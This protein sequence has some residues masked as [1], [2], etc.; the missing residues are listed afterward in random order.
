MGFGSQ[1]VVAVV[2]GIGAAGTGDARRV[3]FVGHH[4]RATGFHLRH[5]RHVE[6]HTAN[7]EVLHPGA[8]AVVVHPEVVVDPLLRALVEVAAGPDIGVGVRL[9]DVG[10]ADVGFFQVNL[11]APVVKHDVEIPDGPLRAFEGFRYLEFAAVAF[12]AETADR[13]GAVIGAVDA[14]IFLVTGLE[15]GTIAG[16]TAK[17]QAEGDRQIRRGGGGF[18][19]S[20]HVDLFVGGGVDFRLAVGQR[21]INRFRDDGVDLLLGK[22]LGYYRGKRRKCGDNR[23]S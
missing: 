8:L 14:D 19:V 3:G 10:D 23:H 6:L 16:V 2:A 5:R 1:R 20:N 17:F 15:V 13:R 12:V 9:E 22:L 18:R 4:F 21:F 11:V 7:I